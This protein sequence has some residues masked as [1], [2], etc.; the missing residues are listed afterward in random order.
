MHFLDLPDESSSFDDVPIE[1]I[2]QSQGSKLR[3]REFGERAKPDPSDPAKNHIEE[4][5]CCTGQ[6]QGP[7]QIH[8]CKIEVLHLHYCLCVI[9][10]VHGGVGRTRGEGCDGGW[11]EDQTTGKAS[12]FHT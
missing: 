5:G 8:A 12:G 9:H 10:S 6:E 3:A 4:A 2:P 11:L 7:P 1:L